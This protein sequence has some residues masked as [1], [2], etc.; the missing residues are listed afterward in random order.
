[1][2]I[3]YDYYEGNDHEVDEY[4]YDKGNDYYEEK[5]YDLDYDAYDKDNVDEYY[6]GDDYYGSISGPSYERNK[7]R[8]R[9]AS[10][11]KKCSNSEGVT[12]SLD[13]AKR[14]SRWSSCSLEDLRKY[15]RLNGAQNFC[16][17]PDKNN[18]GMRRQ[19][20]NSILKQIKREDII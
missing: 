6:T 17:N 4:A 2:G 15:I 9:Y 13:T 14:I 1:M 18:P 5:H 8:F 3:K 7:E 19:S 16:L 11:G 20:V 10:D 12:S